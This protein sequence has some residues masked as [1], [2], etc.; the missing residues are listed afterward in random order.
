MQTNYIDDG[1]NDKFASYHWICLFALD[2]S[3]NQCIIVG[4]CNFNGL[5]NWYNDGTMIDDDHNHQMH[6]NTISALCAE[7][8]WM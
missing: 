1:R 8:E 2:K 5:A 6:I 4:N 7:H 3:N